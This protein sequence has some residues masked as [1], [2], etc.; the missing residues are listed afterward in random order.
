MF[1]A[2]QGDVEA[3]DKLLNSGADI[4]ATNDVRVMYTISYRGQCVMKLQCS[5][6][7]NNNYCQWIHV[8][9]NFAR[10]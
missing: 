3:T 4:D 8:S 5:L 2:L 1:T 6:A 7:P 9:L 10:E